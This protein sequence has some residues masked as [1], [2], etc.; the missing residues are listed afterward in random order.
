MYMN[1]SSKEKTLPDER[2]DEKLFKQ[3]YKAGL[4][5]KELEKNRTKK[6]KVVRI[7]LSL[8]LVLSVVGS[9]SY[10]IFFRKEP[11]EYIESIEVNKQTSLSVIKDEFEVSSKTL[12]VSI[13]N[14]S[15]SSALVFNGK[16]GSVIY[17]KNIDEKL[18]IASITKLIS[19]MVALDS[20]NIED[21]VDVSLE[22]IP[23]DLDWKLELKDGDRIKIDY[24]L[25][26]MLL[27]SFNDSAIVLAN[28]YPN[29]YDAFVSAM[30]R[31]AK[32]LGMDSS[33]FDNPAG[34]D[35]EKNFSTARDV[36]KLVSAVLNYKYILDITDLGGTKISW[37]SG[38]ELV[39]E[40]VYSTNK[41]YGVNRYVKGLKTGITD[42]AKQCFV[43]Y[44]V[45]D[46][47]NE[48][49]TVIL[50]S[51]DRFKDTERLEYLS[52]QVLK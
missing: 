37:N 3:A 18:P 35:S 19:V 41:L 29:G 8:L 10:F 26:S 5:A 25:K 22:N 24:L 43:G 1:S 20:M 12:G 48:L 13:S 34:L 46:N 47:M 42:M 32:S 11:P 9:L 39:S 16:N 2:Y 23:E 7:V 45:Y 6:K 49:V 31:K 36:G 15:A 51:E 38:D 40:T 52:R 50:G 21:S 17:E 33:S 28:A 4:E 30:N 44:F 14:I 27:S